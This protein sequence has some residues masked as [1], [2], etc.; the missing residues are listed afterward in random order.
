MAASKKS[1]PSPRQM[2]QWRAL[3]KPVRPVGGRRVVPEGAR[4]SSL[5]IGHPVM[6]NCYMCS[7]MVLVN[8]GNS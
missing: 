6:C 1:R 4:S 7:T 5:M 8:G 2:A 3:P